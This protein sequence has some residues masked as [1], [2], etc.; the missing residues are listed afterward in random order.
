MGS[1]GFRQE[2]QEGS[3][4]PRLWWQESYVSRVRLE[5]DLIVNF[6]RFYSF[7]NGIRS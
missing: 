6:L 4:D 2:D 1:H 7:S 5:A 3:E